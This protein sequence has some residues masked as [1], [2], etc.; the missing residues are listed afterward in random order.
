VPVPVAA[1]GAGVPLPPPGVGAGVPPVVGKGVVPRPGVGL[2]VS[3]QLHPHVSL[4]SALSVN[5]HSSG[6]MR[7]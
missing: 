2:G 1:V 6:G 3:G 4:A 7:P 5:A